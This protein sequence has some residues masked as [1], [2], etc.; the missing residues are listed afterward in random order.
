MSELG[1]RMAAEMA[2]QPAVL[3]ALADRFDDIAGQVAALVS[4]PV[5]GVAFLARGSSDN[6]AL[7]GRYAVELSS[8][9]PTCLVAPSVMTAYDRTP[10]G[11]AGW[12]VVALSQSGRT[13]E[14]VD[15][16]NRFSAV[17]ATVVAIT[18][19]EHSDLAGVARLTVG[20][21][22][23]REVAV[24]A[25]KTV[26][27]QMLATLAVTAGL[28][29]TPLV[30]HLAELPAR[31]A[32]VLGDA[33]AVEEA[34]ERLAPHRRLAVVA[35]G[36]CYPAALET[37]LKLQ[38]TTGAMAQGFSTA[39]FRHGPIAVCGPDAPALLMG[40]TG[41]ADSDT[42]RLRSELD[43]RGAPSVL[44]GSAAGDDVPWPAADG[45]SDCL[46]AVVRG[47]QLAL[48]VCRRRG[49]DPDQPAGLNKVTL[50]R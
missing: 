28:G 8:G 6:A 33:A 27:A 26:T 39:D 13:P 17:G 9:L 1:I 11:F 24:P 15:L 48:A 42:R 29:G 32:G 19:D 47:Q 14:I 36:L 46:L 37:A 22:A 5:A 12:V 38:E 50:T 20:L 4:G 25:T 18:N 34:A 21:R 30:P 45:A 23:G 43:Q 40:G 35:R 7:L 41:P 10:Q 3:A 49:I 31:V 2:E 16:A 44:A